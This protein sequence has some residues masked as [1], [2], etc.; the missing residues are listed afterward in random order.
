[1]TFRQKSNI[2]L[3]A[4]AL[5]SLLLLF[6]TFYRLNQLTN[7]SQTRLPEE[8]SNLNKTIL[9]KY[10]ADKTLFYDEVLTQS[11]RNFVFTGQEKWEQRYLKNEKKLDLTIA[12][13]IANGEEKD[14][15]NFEKLNKANIELV[16]MEERAFRLQKDGK[17]EEGIALLESDAYWTLKEDYI[18]SIEEY[19]NSK[20]AQLE[21][22]VASIDNLVLQQAASERSLTSTIKTSLIVYIVIFLLLT[23][24][25]TF[26]MVKLVV[27][28]LYA[29]KKGAANIQSGDFD[30]KI[31]IHSKD[32][33]G[34]L[35]EAFNGMAKNLRRMVNKVNQEV[36]KQELANQ[37]DSF[38]REL[39]DRLGIIVSSLKLQ[40]QN[41]KLHL[42]SSKASDQTYSSSIQLVDEAYSQ[43]REI[44]NNPVPESI[45]KNGF[46]K[47]LSNLFSR[48]E[49]IFSLKSKF[50]TNIKEED[51]TPIQKS[52]LYALIREL[53]NNAV[54]HA[55]CKQISCQIINHDDYLSIVFEDDGIG[56]STND[57]PR[58]KGN[59]LKN[60]KS[61]IQELGG[62][63]EIDALPGNGTTVLIELEHKTQADHAKDQL[64]DL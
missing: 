31:N 5:L 62:R 43:L 42:I 36:L 60:A 64:I 11:A 12:Q 15:N 10:L 51:L 54:K 63:I 47:S 41:L 34:D 46:K 33:F 21:G 23:W 4:K 30:Y 7:I 1:M 26:F 19:M 37:R 50:I 49:M 20:D 45:Q 59:G 2:Y 14:K 13:A 8:I 29:L 28:N 39:H 48:T 9:I 17:K 24:T 16:R 55:Q 32:E 56:F 38:S 57:L 35:G 22:L 44:S 52:S 53:L 58:L 40:I 6:F 61:R 27:D 18:E 25:F 3:V